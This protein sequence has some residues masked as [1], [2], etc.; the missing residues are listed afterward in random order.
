MDPQQAVIPGVRII[1]VNLDTQ[2]RYETVSGPAGGF[3]LPFLAPG[4]YRVEAESS[5]F[6]RYVRERVQVSA[7]QQVGLDIVMDVGDVI[8]TVTVS[9]EAPLLVT[10]TASSGQVISERMI[11]DIPMN[12]R[13]PLVL[14][15]LAF[16]VIPSSD[17]RFTRP[18]DNA[19]PSGFSMGGTPNRSNE[20]LLDGSPDT[21]QNRRVAYNPPVDT[22]QEV[23]VETF[24]ADA[25]YGNT[26]GG[27][28][29]VVLKGGSNDFHGNVYNFNQV[30]KLAATDFFV[31]RSGGKKGQLVYNQ[32]GVNAGGPLLV[33]KIYNGKNRVFWHFAYEGIKDRIPEPDQRTVPT[34]AER[35]GDFSA[36][37][38]LGGNYQIYDPATGVREG[39]R[40]RRQPFPNN[41]I[42][43]SRLNPVAQNYL[44]FYPEPNIAGE[45]DGRNNFQANATRGDDFYNVMGRLDVN[46]SDKHKFFY[47]FRTNTRTEFRGFAFGLDN[48]SNGN[49]LRRIN[50]GSTFDDVYTFN[51]TTFLNVRANWTRFTEGSRRPS[52]GF[53]MTSLGFP[54]SL[55]AAVSQAVMPQI[56]LRDFNDLG[57]SGDAPFPFDQWQ[58]FA[59]V[60]KIV[61]SHSL[62]F[63][64]DLRLLR[65]NRGSFGNSSGFYQFRENWVVGPLDNSSRAPLG[66]DFASFLL[67]LPT[68]GRFDVAS[69]FST[70]AGYW[71]FFLQDDW[72]VA[73]NFTLNLGVRW[74]KETAT[75]ERFNR[76][77]VG[78]DEVTANRATDAARAA[79]AANPIPELA[80]TNFNPVGGVLMA[81]E[82]NR[83]IT[84]TPS[85][86]FS[87]RVGFAFTPASLGGRTVLRGGF[88][89]FYFTQGVQRPQQPGCQQRTQMVPTLDS[90]L[91]VNADLSDPFPGG[92]LQPKNEGINTFLGQSVTFYNPIFDNPYS[93]RWT[94]NIQHELA[95]NLVLEA[96]YMGNH[97]VRLA[98]DRDLNF[99]PRNFLSTSP[100]RDQAVIDRMTRK[101]ANPFKGLLPGTSLNGSTVSASQLLRRFAQ[102]SGDDG[103]VIDLDTFGSSYF[104]MFQTRLEKRFSGGLQ[105]IANYQFSKLIARTSFLNP[106]DFAPEKRIADEDRPHR[107]V[108]SGT[109]ELPFGAG[110]PVLGGARGVA[111][112]IA[113]GWSV[114]GVYTYSSGDALDWGN[115]IYFG[116]PL[117]YEARNV[118]RAFDTSRF[119]TDSK[120]Q[121][122]WN[123]R[124]FPSQFTT[125]REAATN[126]FDISVLKNFP[127][128]ERFKLQYRAEFFNT[129]NHPA[130]DN[131]NTSPT[132]SS[133][134]RITRQR[135]L[136]RVVQM[137]LKLTW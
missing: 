99:V 97:A 60:N 134:G 110:K 117:D 10:S 135:N 44:K 133:F 49:F 30:S 36:L 96:G 4:P 114:S 3:T 126:N 56:D 120:R 23:K 68:S 33:P 103:V 29:N 22:V 2:A 92:I 6:K 53:D 16:G 124:T 57:Q 54:Q 130:F 18:F 88:G 104:H 123:I 93:V 131:A 83:A 128:N 42:P 101:V 39:G 61:G 35:R 82:Q 137:A 76:Q 70:Q 119:E 67:G 14:A 127:I 63:G 48:I 17:P 37:L 91:T 71:S 64:A 69:F 95:R 8:E 13:T 47:N 66:Q 115:V 19:G 27:T 79:Y 125:Y 109:Y 38:G 72:K 74:E 12:G 20:L 43:Q 136:P 102:F 25:A 24:Q 129:F 34:A 106:S 85:D 107:F 100:F 31:N 111:N 62:K 41:V 59:T 77:V 15:Q 121:L 5:G 55:A 89:L 9:A 46:V 98:D 73:R 11:A 87:P 26:G 86:L 52:L 116:G 75:T 118:D 132:S 1:A 78:F 50:Y 7:N 21:T 51:P 81:T 84:T 45:R 94:F 90:F 122:E 28:V 112:Q 80:A 32:W 108:F 65:E 58:I 113:G 105:F 40:I